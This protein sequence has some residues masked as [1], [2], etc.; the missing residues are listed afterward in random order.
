MTHEHTHD[1]HCEHHH[2]HSH[3]DSSLKWL[4]LCIAIG[5]I[6][7]GYF[8]G[9]TLYK[10]R[11]AVNTATVKGLAEEKMKSDLAVWDMN[12]TM[13][14]E[15]LEAAYAAADEKKKIAHDFLIDKGFDEKDLS[16]NTSGFLQEFRDGDGVLQDKKYQVTTYVTIRTANVDKVE[17]VR[18]SVG[19]LMKDGVMMNNNAPN[20]L[21][22]GLNDIKP[23]L[24][25]EATKNARLAAKQFAEDAGAKVGTIQSASQGSFSITAFDGDQNYEVTDMTSLYKK[26]RVVTTIAFYL[27]D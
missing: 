11:V 13:E 23:K 2:P 9:N 7:C 3:P 14:A 24:L 20:Y 18:Q 17:D 15:T 10:S 26:V 6:G 5:L 12:F 22:T 16:F 25:Q 19:D 21:F 8:I 1:E 4:G 27:N